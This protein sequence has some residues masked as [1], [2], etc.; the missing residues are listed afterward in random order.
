MSK[1]FGDQKRFD[2]NGDGRLGANEWFNWYTWKYG[3]D[4]ENQERQAVSSEVGKW[5][6]WLN[7]ANYC[8]ESNHDRFFDNAKELITPWDANTQRLAEHT[9]IG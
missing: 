3:I 8:V 4:I 5:E 1:P 9:Y 7:W 2:K 6:S